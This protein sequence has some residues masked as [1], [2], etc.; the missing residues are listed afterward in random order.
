MN[1]SQKNCQELH[2]LYPREM[3]TALT[4]LF[5]MFR[6]FLLF[7]AFPCLE[8]LFVFLYEMFMNKWR[9]KNEKDSIL[10]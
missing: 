3:G 1:Q 8:R 2:A 6:V 9:R 10:W 5:A 7:A 4:A